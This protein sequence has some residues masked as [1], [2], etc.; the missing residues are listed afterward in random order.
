MIKRELIRAYH[1]TMNAG[2]QNN[3]TRNM[4]GTAE[5]PGTIMET[6][7]HPRTSTEH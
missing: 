3:G 4:G 1:K 6:T 5:H 2:T 7:E